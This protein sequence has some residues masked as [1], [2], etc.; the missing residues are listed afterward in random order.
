MPVAN[1]EAVKEQFV[2]D[3]NTV[4]EMRDIPQQLVLAGTKPLSTLS[5]AHHGLWLKGSK[6]VEIVGRGNK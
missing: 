3:V 5:L 4:I 6:Q 1:F 2:I